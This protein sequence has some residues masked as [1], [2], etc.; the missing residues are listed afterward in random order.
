VT[1]R[2]HERPSPAESVCAQCA[3]R[4]TLCC[5]VADGEKLATLSVRDIERI[6]EATDLPHHRFVEREKL[7][8]MERLAYETFRPLLRGLFAGNV[9]LALKARAGACVFLER[10]KGCSLPPE[11]KPIACKLYPFDYDLAGHLTLVDAPHC[12]ALSLA[13]SEAALLRMFGVSR[14]LLRKLRQQT[15]EEAADHARRGGRI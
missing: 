7:D 14:R 4:G 11:A 6:T 3:E 12:L 15:L 9:R 1:Q 5:L 10:G 8:P 2:P 13:Q